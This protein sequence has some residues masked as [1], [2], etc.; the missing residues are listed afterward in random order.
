MARKRYL[1]IG[2][3]AAGT[4]AAQYVRQADPQGAITILS[5]DPSPAYFRAALTNYLL[6]ELREDQIWAV[7]PTFYGEHQVQR[8]LTRVASVDTARSV[9]WLASGAPEAYDALLVAAGARARPPTW[10]GAWLPGVMTMRTL[11]DVRR[12]M[13]L[14]K[15]H[16]IQRALVVGGGPLALEWA[17]GMRARGVKVTMVVRETKFL[18]GALDAV[19]SD[20]LLARLRQAGVEVRVGEQVRAALPGRDGRVGAAMLQSGETIPCEL[21]AAA[22]GVICNSD[23]LQ[24]TPIALGKSGGIVVDDRLRTTVPNVYAAG[25]VAEIGG[26]LSQLWEP[27]RHQGR[28]AAINMIGGDAVYA[29]GVHYMATRLYDLDF[30]SLGTTGAAVPGAEEVVDYPRHTGRIS[31]KKLVIRDGK[32]IGAMMLGEREEKVR[33]RGRAWKRL[34]DEGREIGSIKGL[35]LD[36]SFDLTGWLNT[37]TLTAKPDDAPQASALAS[38]SKLKGTQALDFSSLPPLPGAPVLRPANAPPKAAAQKGT[39]LVAAPLALSP[40]IAP[41]ARPEKKLAFGTMLIAMEAPP[42]AAEPPATGGAAWLEAAGRKWDLAASTVSVGR[43]PQ[44]AIAL[45]DPHVSHLHAQITRHGDELYLRDLGSASGSWV[46]GAPVTVPHRLREGDRVRFGGVELLFRTT[47]GRRS[48]ALPDSMQDASN[49]E[50]KPHLDVRAGSGLGLSF[51]LAQPEITIGRNPASGI[52]LDDYSVAW[53]HALLRLH[54]GLFWLR[55]QGM[56]E[57]VWRNGQRLAPQQDVALQENDVLRMGEAELVFVT[58]PVAA[59]H[60]TLATR[61]PSTAPPVIKAYTPAPAMAM[62]AIVACARC[63]VPLDPQAT[64]CTSCGT[65]ARAKAAP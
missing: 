49:G 23:F 27:A 4:T 33:A 58:K 26:R 37:M 65:P 56:S 62:Q 57:G 8:V 35:L 6:G 21:I 61:P 13:D 54:N 46:N 53:N 12:V 11:Q 50:R 48:T 14:I 18:P 47:S 22:I 51:V 15:L 59:G 28:T 36:A 43:D 3:G 41:G 52:R 32:L 38:P 5:D 10:D 9:A 34:I 24:N 45:T 64:F 55:D 44:C 2:D 30:A 60:P 7:P 39:A 1:I 42:S 31:Y 29:P 20:L 25:D 16:G 63:G 40:A 17:Q 19:G